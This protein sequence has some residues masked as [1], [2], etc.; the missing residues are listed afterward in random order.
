MTLLT[1]PTFF[2]LLHSFNTHVFVLFRAVLAEDLPANTAMMF[3]K[4]EAELSSAFLAVSSLTIRYIVF[5]LTQSKCVQ[6]IDVDV[7][8]FNVSM[9]QEALCVNVRLR[10]H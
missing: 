2:I 4:E 9:R 6:I 3:S 7:W 8:L 10:N 1:H 5:L